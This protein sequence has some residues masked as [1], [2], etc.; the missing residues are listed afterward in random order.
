MIDAQR[1]TASR[2]AREIIEVRAFVAVA[3]A[4]HPL[5][6]PFLLEDRGLLFA[7]AMSS[8]AVGRHRH[9]RAFACAPPP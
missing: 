1:L 2:Q 8:V 7:P 4:D 5:I 6:K 9:A 3:A